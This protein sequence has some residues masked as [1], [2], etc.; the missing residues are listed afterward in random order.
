[1]R[2]WNIMRNGIKRLHFLIFQDPDK[3]V[4]GSRR[5]R[6]IGRLHEAF[7]LYW[8]IYLKRFENSTYAGMIVEPLSL[9]SFASTVCLFK[10]LN[11]GMPML[12]SRY[13]LLLI[14][15]GRL[16]LVARS[17]DDGKV[18]GFLMFHFRA[19]E[20]PERTVHL[21]MM[22]TCPSARRKGLAA[23]MLCSAL[24]HYSHLGFMKV[25]SRT[26][27]ANGAALATHYRTGF[28]TVSEYFD[29]E[30]MER[31]AYLECDLEPYRTCES[32][33]TKGGGEDEQ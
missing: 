17:P 18:V 26:A 19:H 14:H 10:E 7:N 21:F 9:A 4:R 33:F 2:S 27:I 12:P 28:S 5:S 3:M 30:E 22:G 15:R 25:T 29:D 31:M 16:C 11:G 24:C 23:H 32:T 1:M 13:A 20:Y 6:W 8:G